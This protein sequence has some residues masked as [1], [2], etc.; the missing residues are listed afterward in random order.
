MKRS[1]SKTTTRP[2][3]NPLSHER[4]P[5]LASAHLFHSA[6][7]K[8]AGLACALVLGAS[9]VG[10][11]T[12]AAIEDASGSEGTTTLEGTARPD[13][14]DDDVA[15]DDLATDDVGDDVD[16]SPPAASDDDVTDAEQPA[17]EEAPADVADGDMPTDD[18][19][20]VGELPA[21][22]EN[23]PAE[24][25]PAEPAPAEPAPAEPPPSAPPAQ[26]SAG[27]LHAEGRYLIDTCGN[28]LVVRGVEQVFG[29]GIDV[30]G[31]FDTLVD[32][33]A[34][35]GANAVRVL[36]NLEQLD[37]AAVDA[38][39]TRITQQGMVVF[40][41]PGDRS[42]FARSDVKAMLDKH[43][44]WLIIDAFQEPNYDDRARWKDD[45]ISAIQTI[46]AQGYTVPVTA[47][48]NQYGRDLPA[49]LQ[50]GAE[51]VKADSQ[52]N[53]ILG[54]QAYWGEGGW[55]QGEYGMTLT[56]AV[57][58]A[59]Q[60]PFPIQAGIDGFADP[61]E[62]MDYASTMAES[63]ESQVGWLWWDWYNPFGPSNNLTVDGTS[64]NLTVLGNEV[65]LGNANGLRA[66]HKACVPAGG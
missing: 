51:V 28:R 31:S 7:R 55:Y 16:L 25:A 34:K 30:N 46:R 21:Q 62:A 27:T 45:A 37:V 8:I 54:W 44:A 11:A 49:L 38:I 1:E 22:P 4:D 20:D 9:T 36:P 56:Q 52:S 47:L 14:A 41:S 26:P 63:Q 48:A 35:S 29:F 33:I 12:G 53:T 13:D 24:P 32:E 19:G 50:H 3:L 59:A 60:Q 64:S 15:D 65:V 39:L 61:G 10:C 6:T 43:K 40:I 2:E 58:T 18:V 5:N 42:W 23:P 57:E 17:D 66:A